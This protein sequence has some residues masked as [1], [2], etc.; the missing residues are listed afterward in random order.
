[1]AE[2]IKTKTCR[3]CKQ[4]KTLT[5]FYKRN[6]SKDGHRNDCKVCF[7]KMVYK[8]QQTE[9]YKAT[10]KRYRQSEKGKEVQRKGT[11]RYNQS[12]KGKAYY[13]KYRKE[14]NVLHPEQRNARNAVIHAIEKGRLPHPD[15]LQC[16]CGEPA[17]HYHHK[18]YAKEHWLDVIPVCTKCHTLCH[19]KI[20]C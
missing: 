17:K 7:N 19:K 1:M 2:P 20:A 9:K 16:S 10:K 11:F 4:T 14:Y 18:S 13:R 5:E 6:S 8:Y 15:S 3:T 12:E